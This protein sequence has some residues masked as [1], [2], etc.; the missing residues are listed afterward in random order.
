MSTP[1]PRQYEPRPL[2]SAGTN[3]GSGAA[4]AFF[5]LL[6]IAGMLTVAIVGVTEDAKRAA[7]PR[8]P[9]PAAVVTIQAPTACGCCCAAHR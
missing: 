9:E 3:D 8:T 6:V 4:F 7:H 5:L 1:D 2:R